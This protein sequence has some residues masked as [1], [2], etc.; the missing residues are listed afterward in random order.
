MGSSSSSSFFFLFLFSFFFVFRFFM[1]LLLILFLFLLLLLVRRL[2]T[3]N[4]D[5]SSFFLELGEGVE[6]SLLLWRLKFY[7]RGCSFV[8]RPCWWKQQR[9][10]FPLFVLGAK[11]QMRPGRMRTIASGGLKVW[12][13]GSMPF[14]RISKG[15]T[16]TRNSGGTALDFPTRTT[17]TTWN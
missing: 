5:V 11:T 1:V 4:T 2:G 10:A 17:T 13:S 12:E 6:A 7:I 14:P 3:R 16:R 8:R 9:A 15:R